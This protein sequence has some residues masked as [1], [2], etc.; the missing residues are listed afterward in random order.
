MAIP[1]PGLPPR[2]WNL[3]LTALSSQSPARYRRVLDLTFLPTMVLEIPDL[4]PS[5]NALCPDPQS[6]GLAP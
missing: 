1:T 2:T 3:R 4:S 6:L 5:L